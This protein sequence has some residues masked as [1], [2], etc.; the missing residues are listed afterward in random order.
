M[1]PTEKEVQLQNK[2]DPKMIPTTTN[3][4]TISTRAWYP[5]TLSSIYQRA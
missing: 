3:S 5:K 2:W 1:P 4:T